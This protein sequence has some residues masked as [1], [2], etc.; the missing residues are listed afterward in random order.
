M[1][2]WGGEDKMGRRVGVDKMEEGGD[3]RGTAV[4]STYTPPTGY[5]YAPSSGYAPPNSYAPQSK[6]GPSSSGYAPQPYQAPTLYCSE[7]SSIDHTSY[8]GNR[9]CDAGGRC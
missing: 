1:I 6:H 5:G 3:K 8:A 9:C 4:T 2:R 7:Y